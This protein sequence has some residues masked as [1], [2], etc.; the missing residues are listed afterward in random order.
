LE[1]KIV[2]GNA[3][4]GFP[5]TWQSPATEKVERLKRAYFLETDP[6]R[7]ASLRAQ[8]DAAIQ[9]H[10]AN[11][12]KVIGYPVDFDFRLFF[13]EVFHE[14]GG[15]DVV[16]G[17]PP[18]FNVETLGANSSIVEQLKIKYKHIWMDKSDILFYFI[19]KAIDI[20]KGIVAFIVSNAF[21]FA[22]KA[23]KLRNYIL[24]KA[25]IAKIVNF[26]QYEV[27]ESTMVTTAIIFLDKSKRSETAK[28]LI[29]DSGEQKITDILSAMT[30]E[31][32]FFNVELSRDRV[33]ALVDSKIECANKKIDN[34]HKKLNELFEIGSGMQ[35]GANRIFVFA[36]K[37]QFDDRFIRKRVSSSNIAKYCLQE[38]T[39]EYI[40]YIENIEKFELLPADI[41]QYLKENKRV[42]A[43]RADKKRRKTAK[44]WNYTFPMHKEL[45]RRDKIWCSYR[46][47]TNIFA[48]DDTTEEYLGLTNT[49]VIFDTNKDLS[50]KYLLALLNSKTLTFRYRT[51]G[52]QTGNGLFE[53]FANGVGKLP[54]P[55]ISL[56]KQRVFIELVDRILD[57]KA[58][59]PAADV[60]ALEAEIDRLVYQLYGLTED[61]IAIIEE[62]TEA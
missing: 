60:S 15:F 5:E 32:K 30:E 46:S 26:E 2:C 24:S 45:Y 14:Q 58:A 37:P 31:S 21:L 3:L 10:L 23:K 18:Y 9:Q 61:E 27:F 52:K 8:I 25:P 56:K 7:K 16:I 44:W 20:T 11:T 57:A 55:V 49:T 1:Y 41:Q 13:S 47:R 51:I 4:L 12:E 6:A 36:E 19:S 50:I 17:N 35:T 62:T 48:Y 40:L 59:D 42:L 53:F 29:I 39:K 22:A 38:N 54:V 33:F 43:G 34:N 28:A